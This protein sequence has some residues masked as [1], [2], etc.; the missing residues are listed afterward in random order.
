[1]G[2]RI[3]DLDEPRLAQLFADEGRGVAADAPTTLRDRSIIRDRPKLRSKRVTDP[4]IFI[5]RP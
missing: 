5:G 4:L 3:A 2:H 1:M